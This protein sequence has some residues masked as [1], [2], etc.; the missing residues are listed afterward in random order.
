MSSKFKN[1]YST[2]LV[3]AA[4]LTPKGC[5]TLFLGKIADSFEQKTLIKREVR[6][7]FKTPKKTG[8]EWAELQSRKKYFFF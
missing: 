8:L 7:S 6:D 3:G 1:Y 4:P 5:E 2:F